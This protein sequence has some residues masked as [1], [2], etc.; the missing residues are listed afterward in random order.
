MAKKGSKSADPDKVVIFVEV[1]P[2][3]KQAMEEIAT[4]HER[5]LTGEATVAFKQYI[6]AH[7]KEKGGAK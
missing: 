4:E 5:S 7:K 6:E 1:A 3:I 2:W